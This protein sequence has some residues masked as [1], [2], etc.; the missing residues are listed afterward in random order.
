MVLVEIFE[1]VRDLELVE[2]RYEFSEKWLGR[3]R[4]YYS[5]IVSSNRE[6]SIA[7]LTTLKVRLEALLRQSSDK[8]TGQIYSAEDER[9]LLALEQVKCW[10]DNI[11]T[12]RC[13]A[14]I[15]MR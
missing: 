7:A 8:S 15:V 12:E 11:V 13:A 10:V 3:C 2:S 6:P 4:S 1:V 5:A 14:E 9:W